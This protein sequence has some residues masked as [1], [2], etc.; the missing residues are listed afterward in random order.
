MNTVYLVKQGLIYRFIKQ[1]TPT[2]AL[3]PVAKF[4]GVS[5]TFISDVAKELKVCSALA[6]WYYLTPQAI[7]ITV[8]SHGGERIDTPPPVVEDEALY[9]YRVITS[10]IP[11][12]QQPWLVRQAVVAGVVP[13]HG[14]MLTKGDV[15]LALPGISEAVVTHALASMRAE[16][17]LTL[18]K[19]GHILPS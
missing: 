14:E 8:S 17:L 11:R 3:T 2:Y 19:R 15:M 1:H 6:G 4:T 9:H 13:T 16:G 5:D 10:A 18:T 7:D 12:L